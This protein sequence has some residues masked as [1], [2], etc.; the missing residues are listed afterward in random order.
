M[1]RMARK[2]FLPILCAAAAS[3]VRLAPQ[4]AAELPSAVL[5]RAVLCA[6]VVR[7]NDWAE[8]ALVGTT[9]SKGRDASVCSV[10]EFKRLSGRHRLLWKWYGPD[11]RLVRTSDPTA[12]GKEGTE[13]DRY[14]AWDRLALS[15]A[16][17]EGR[18]TVAF[19]IDDQTAGSKEFEL[20]SESPAGAEFSPGS[21]S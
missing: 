19:F 12:V 1:V 6:D 3:C 15:A 16:T 11:G 4:T 2:F 10:L 18:W 17:L 8:P 7:T 5:D 14:I 13:Y 20:R 21:G 9:F